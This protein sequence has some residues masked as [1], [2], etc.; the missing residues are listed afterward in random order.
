MRKQ[1]ARTL[2]VIYSFHQQLQHNMFSPS[3]ATA[4]EWAASKLNLTVELYC[5][6]HIEIYDYFKLKTFSRP[7]IEKRKKNRLNKNA[8][9]QSGNENPALGLCPKVKKSGE[10]NCIES[11]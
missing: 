10:N 3:P 8:T 7:R 5:A 6:H 2:C 1:E 11:N 4:P 9:A